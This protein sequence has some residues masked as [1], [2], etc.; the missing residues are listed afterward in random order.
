[1]RDA[2]GERPVDVRIIPTYGS[3]P[4]YRL[5]VTYFIEKKGWSVEQL[6]QTRL[7][8]DDALATMSADEKG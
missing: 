3:Y 8:L 5:L 6:L 4:R 2:L 1:L 7:S